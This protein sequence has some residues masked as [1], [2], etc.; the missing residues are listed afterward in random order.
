MQYK[1]DTA[2]LEIDDEAGI[3][4]GE[5]LG[6]R[7]VITFQGETVP[8]ARQS[9]EESV[10]FYLRMCADEGREPETPFS[11]KFLLR[12]SP[13]LHRSL[14]AEAQAKRVSLN[15]LVTEILASGRVENVPAPAPGDML[16]KT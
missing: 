14:S 8:E 9:F 13:E 1:G 6:I 4:F 11:G 7:D 16:T 15:D 3:L 10:D 2:S 12:I 5:V